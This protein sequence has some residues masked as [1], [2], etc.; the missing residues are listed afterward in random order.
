MGRCQDARLFP[1]LLWLQIIAEERAQHFSTFFLKHPRGLNPRFVEVQRKHLADEGG[2]IRWDA[3][4]IEWL[5]P[6][7]PRFL[8]RINARILGWALRE[9]FHLPK[10]S[11]W[12]VIVLLMAEFRDLAAKER[13][14]RE[15]MEGL[16]RNETYL[17]TLYPR[18]VFPRTRRLAERWPELGFLDRFFT[19]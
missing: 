15:A 19:G 13:E 4:L 2:H 8:R 6:A 10:R 3:E 11:G 14:L 9:F 5:W 16:A 18:T 1:C 12:N 17:R 7:T